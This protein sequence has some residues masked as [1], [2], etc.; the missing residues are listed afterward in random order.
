MNE[1]IAETLLSTFGLQGKTA[2]VTG[3]GS[4]IGKAT[5]SLF[6]RVGA[7]VAV[8]G[9]REETVR[10]VVEN[11]IADGGEAM[12]VQVE[13]SEEEQ[14]R[15]AF[16]RVTQAWGAPDIL[17]NNA[18][19]RVKVDFMEMSVE[20]WDRMHQ[21][22]TRGTFLCM[23]EAIRGMRAKGNGGVI[24]NVSSVGAVHP[25][26]MSSTHY[27]SSKAGINALT[28][29]SALEFAPD[30]IRINAILPGGTDTEGARNIMSSGTMKPGPMADM[31]R[32]LKG[33]FARPDEMASIILFLASPAAE[34]VNG[35]LL[36][37]DGGFM[38]S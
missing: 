22:N 18:A 33:R 35:Q 10:P 28:R 15:R 36:V 30:G 8:A 21:V 14:V 24:V 32:H 29:T 38:V 2:F 27:D 6:A 3:A 11:I 9:R 5:A 37:A 25:V 16:A 19:H 1:R 7:R 34:F 20:Q 26:A 4:G 31:K 17:V 13:V 23:R 12:A